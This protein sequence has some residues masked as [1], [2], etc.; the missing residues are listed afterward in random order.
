[1]CADVMQRQ[2]ESFLLVR[3]DKGEVLVR[4]SFQMTIVALM[5]AEGVWQVLLLERSLAMSLQLVF[6]QSRVSNDLRA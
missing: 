5:L 6:A 4:K 3:C 2:G 1:M